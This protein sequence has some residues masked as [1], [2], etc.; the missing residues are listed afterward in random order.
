MVRGGEA[1]DSQ[2]ALTEAASDMGRRRWSESLFALPFYVGRADSWGVV[3]DRCLLVWG[4]TP[5]TLVPR[6]H[7]LR[8]TLSSESG[9]AA[10]A[11][12]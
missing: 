1:G 5:E 3:D 8:S 11:L 10:H 2:E 4:Q 6:Y 9:I 7:L 12:S